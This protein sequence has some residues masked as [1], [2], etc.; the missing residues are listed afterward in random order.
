MK[1]LI[2]LSMLLVISGVALA[3]GNGAGDEEP[4]YAA[5]DPAEIPEPT[6]RDVGSI[7]EKVNEIKTVI[8]NDYEVLLESSPQ[9]M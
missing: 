8:Q 3:Q 7:R 4:T 1:Y 2:I 6:G 5:V 9:A